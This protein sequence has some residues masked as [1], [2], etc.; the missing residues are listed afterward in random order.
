LTD[1]PKSSAS[2]LL[3]D[4]VKTDVPVASVNRILELARRHLE[5]DVTFISQFTAGKQVF[6][7][8]A[9]DAAS[10]GFALGEGPALDSTYCALMAAGRIPNAVPDAAAHPVLS[11]LA[12]T[13]DAGIGSYV[14]VPILLPDGSLYGSLCGLGHTRQSVDAR[15]AR[16]LTLLAELVAHELDKERPDGMLSARIR[17]LIDD[18]DIA[19]ALQPIV[20]LA[21]GGVIGVE[22]LSRFPQG[23]GSPDTV[24]AAAHRVGLGIELEQVT[25]LKAIELLPQLRADQFLALN[26][27]PSTA[28]HF[29][30]FVGG[31]DDVPFDRLVLEITEHAAVDDYAALRDDLAHLRQ[32]GLRLAIDD[33]GAGYASL[34]H[35]VELAPDIIKIDRSLIDGLATDT[36]R[37][38]VVTAFVAL[39]HDIGAQVI[40]E[41][42]EH[43]TDLVAAKSLGVD[44][45]QGYLLARPSTD[46]AELP[47]LLARRYTAAHRM[48]GAS[49]HRPTGDTWHHGPDLG[50]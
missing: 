27:S 22:A 45:V 49:A 39:A 37:R 31:C 15:D 12:G 40:A 30:Q 43:L 11:R 48:P 23:H 20:D 24:F 1:E 8:L 14:G 4:E 46:R 47:R 9:G 26:V 29:A 36:A 21:G 28:L 16:F 34:H 32:R 25:L 13:T 44:L 19:I 5:M 3:T 38:S 10:F 41:G 50:T 42:V 35:I 33:A 2:E 18:Q 7:G 6:R 17:T